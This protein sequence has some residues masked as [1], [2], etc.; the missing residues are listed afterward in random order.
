MLFVTLRRE[1]EAVALVGLGLYVLEAAL[2][3]ASRMA[4]FSLLRLSETYVA[5]GRPAQLETWGSL[6]LEAMEFTGGTLHMVVFCTGALL[7]YALLYASAVIPRAL[8]L[9][10]LLALLPCLFAT[11][12]AILGY[13]VPFLV[14][15]PYVPFEWVVGVWL[16]V[17]GAR[18]RAR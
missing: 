12:A 17:R 8:S 15:V 1:N 5:A 13:A 6:V 4:T 18:E 16:L 2:L 10:G 9:W 3:A 11:V 14:Y 7:F